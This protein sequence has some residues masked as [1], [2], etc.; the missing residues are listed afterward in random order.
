VALKWLVKVKGWTPGD[1]AQRQQ[2]KHVGEQD[3]HEQR[4]DVGNVLLAFLAD[5]GGQQ[6]I[7]E[8]G[9][10][11]DRH[12]PATGNDLALHPAKHEDEQRDGGDRHPQRR[13][14]EGN[15][16]TRN[17]PVI[18]AEKRL[19]RELVHRIDFALFGC[20]ALNPLLHILRERPIR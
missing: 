18:G 6:A 19:D 4:E 2:A 17:L 10:A 11:L 9:H 5:V 14:G 12:L 7:N 20:H 8:A 16:V 15:L 3:E 1:Q 13:I